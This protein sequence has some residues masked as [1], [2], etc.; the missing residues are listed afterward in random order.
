M[1]KDEKLTHKAYYEQ[2]DSTGETAVMLSVAP[3]TADLIGAQPQDT[4]KDKAFV[5]Q[6]NTAYVFL[7]DRSGSMAG[8]RMEVTK[9][10]LT[11]FL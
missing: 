3:T 8:P 10:A 7:V 11:L 5:E 6:V 9:E 4:F 2:R 1:T